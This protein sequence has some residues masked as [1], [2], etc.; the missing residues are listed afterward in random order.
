MPGLRALARSYGVQ[1]FYV[2]T[3]G[4]RRP[5]RPEAVLATL[6]ALGAPIERPADLAAALRGR[7]QAAWA[8]PLEPVSV[9]WAGDA[10]SV[11]LRLTADVTSIEATLVREDGETSGWKVDVTSLYGTGAAE[12]EGVTY[13]A[14]RL[15]LPGRPLPDGYHDLAVEVAGRRC[16]SLVVAAPRHAYDPGERGWGVFLPLYALRT[17][18]SAGIADL[19]DLRAL[20]HWT[21]DHGGDVVATLPLLAAFLDE[22]C[23]YS[24]YT[25]VSRLFWNEL[26]LNM[27]TVA[28]GHA[29]AAAVLRDQTG[30]RAAISE[31]ALVDYRRQFLLNRAVLDQIPAAK[32]LPGMDAAAL[33]AYARFRAVGERQRQAWRQWPARLR[34]GDLRPGDYDESAHRYHVTAQLLTESQLRPLSHSL[35]SGG[36]RLYL[37]YPV[38][39]HPDGFDTW[40]HPHLFAFDASVGAPPDS[41]FTRG[42]DWGFPPQS[43]AALRQDR[44]AYFLAGLRNHLRHAEILRIDHVMGLHRLFWLPRGFEARDGVYVRY[45]AEELYAI[46]CLE[47]QRHRAAV[48]GEDLGTVPRGV[49]QAMARHRIG[50]SYVVELEAR[51]PPRPAL[52]SVPSNAVAGLNTHDMPPLAAYWRGL[53][54]TDRAAL[55]HLDRRRVVS[56]QRARKRLVGGLERFFAVTGEPAVLEASGR[57]LGRSAASLVLVNAEDLWLES[58][59]QNVPG[60]AEQRPNWRRKARYRLEEWDGRPGLTAT[61]A[62]LNQSRKGG[63]HGKASKA[64]PQADHAKAAKERHAVARAV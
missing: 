41:F 3:G 60:T 54:V 45:P 26:Y 49:R 25:P 27:E 61:L 14:Y 32:P 56:E 19:S 18:R 59:P 64:N 22:P 2:D 52:R 21:G 55:G 47:S 11:S 23:D 50:G 7:R 12:I 48:V 15:S 10:P 33:E 40:R 30:A 46:L 34:D 17:A 6:R 35:H 63:R 58:E 44:Y 53:D 13:R 20:A 31:A 37:D 29:E 4:R 5:A 43:P 42:Q 51:E 28:A 38:G 24:P 16:E 9:V 36:Q 62:A 57:F 39:V 8:T 1:D